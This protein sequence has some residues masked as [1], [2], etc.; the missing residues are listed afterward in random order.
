MQ[1]ALK[2]MHIQR[3][4]VL[5]EVTGVTGLAIL[6]AMVAGERRGQVWAKL[7]RPACKKTEE[8]M[9]KALPGTWRDEPLFV[10]QP[11]LA[12][13]AYSTAKMAECDTRIAQQ[14]SAMKPRFAGE[15]DP[16]APPKSRTKQGSK[17]K[18]K[19]SSNGRAHVWRLLGVDLVEV[20][21][22]S[23]S[24]APT[25]SS[26]IGTD[27]SRFPTVKPFCSWRGL[28]PHHDISG[29]RIL[30]SHVMN[31]HHRAG[32]AFRQAA[33]SGARSQS[34]FGAC[35]RAIRGK[36]GAETAVVATA[37]KM[38]RV[39]YHMLKYREAF[40]PESSQALDQNRRQRELHKLQRR[41]K[42]LGD[43]LEPALL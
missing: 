15:G 9:V 2:R 28:A 41:A 29:G 38:A 8:D 30:R 42:A 12:L 14:F 26:E 6:R 11:S 20:S 13:Y 21:G 3:P 4:E 39:V 35:F 36:R 10:R 43:K 34:I 22:I 27:R 37:H 23:A 24:I 1:K 7:R 31:V 33:Q 25:V 19:P 17:S 18:H 40:T 32:Q 16:P 5:A